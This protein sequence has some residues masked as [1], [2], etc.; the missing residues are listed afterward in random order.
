MYP[1]LRLA[2][3]FIIILHYIICTSSDWSKTVGYFHIT[4]TFS[5]NLQ[6]VATYSTGSGRYLECMH[7]C[8][9]SWID[10]TYS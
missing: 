1:V 9:I 4:Y 10:H 8:C 7:K 5:N 3:I 2:C 6:E